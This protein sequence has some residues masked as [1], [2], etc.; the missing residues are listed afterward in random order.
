MIEI[1]R[2]TDCIDW[3]QLIDLYEQTGLVGGL[4]T[5]KDL[6][7]IKK[8]FLNSYRVVSGWDGSH[9]VG[10]GR[11]LSDG[12]CYAM[13]FDIG[14]LPEYR[15]QG[16]ASAIVK[17][18]LVNMENISVHLTSRFGVE[19]LYKKVGFKRHKNAFAKYPHESPYL[20]G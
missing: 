7:G 20:E 5:K 17:E 16:I 6:A 15:R 19:D 10:A 3:T 12:V 11:I 14:V 8:A 18:L 1:K 2:G 13:I 4:G 9:L